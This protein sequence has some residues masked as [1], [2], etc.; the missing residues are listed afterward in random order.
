MSTAVLPSE[1]TG[2]L[3]VV[4]PQ[5]FPDWFAERVLRA[6]AYA[7][8]TGR[9][10]LLRDEAVLSR[11]FLLVDVLSE[12][13]ELRAPYRSD[14]AATVALLESYWPAGRTAA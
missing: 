3:P 8:S 5:V 14:A 4:A 13:I 1:S 9:L 10:R 11:D 7:Y 2:T 12:A 6:A